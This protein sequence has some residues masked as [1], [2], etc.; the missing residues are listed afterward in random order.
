MIE[1]Y[2]IL[3]EGIFCRIRIS[4]NPKTTKFGIRFRHMWE[5]PSYDCCWY[6]FL[7]KIVSVVANYQECDDSWVKIFALSVVVVGFCVA[8]IIITSF[9]LESAGTCVYVCMWISGTVT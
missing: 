6:F 1:R 5:N 7:L 4:S 3:A 9:E 8:T 2:H